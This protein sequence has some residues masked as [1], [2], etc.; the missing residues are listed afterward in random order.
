[1]NQKMGIHLWIP[2]SQKLVGEKYNVSITLGIKE[3]G[4]SSC[5]ISFSLDYYY[6]FGSFDV[7]NALYESHHLRA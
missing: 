7:S 5:C 1:M 3:K 2:I 6:F 4:S